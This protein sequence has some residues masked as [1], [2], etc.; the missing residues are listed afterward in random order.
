MPIR[1]GNDGRFRKNL[2]MA[3]MPDLVLLLPRGKVLW[4]ELKAPTGKQSKAQAQ[5]QLDWSKL[6][7]SYSVI[8]SIEAFEALL[9][10]NEVVFPWR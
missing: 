5:C 2:D 3:G 8:K 6:G 10:T 1:V 7:H 4:V 9:K